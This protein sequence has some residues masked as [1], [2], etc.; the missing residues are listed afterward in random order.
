MSAPVSDAD[1]RPPSMRPAAAPAG[2]GPVGVVGPLLAVLLLALGVLL[3]RDALVTAGTVSGSA[4]LPAVV[5]GLRGTGPA[6][7]LVPAGAV[8]VLVGLWLVVV[9]LRPR[10]RRTLPLTSDTGVFL[11]VRDVARL[12][13]GAAGDVDGVLDASASATRRKVTVTVSGTAAA[14]LREDVTEAVTER[15]AALASAPRVSVLVR[16][17][18][19]SS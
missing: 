16:T 9:A 17:P 12:A 19:E 10:S 5:D 13:A 4:W 18:E 2:S 15:L 3:V 7:W 1:V 14:G 8:V 11:H 6:G